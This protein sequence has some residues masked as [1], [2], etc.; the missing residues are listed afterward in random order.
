M[1]RIVRL[2]VLVVTNLITWLCT[3]FV[4]FIYYHIPQNMILCGENLKYV[5]ENSLGDKVEIFEQ[6][7]DGF[8][9]SVFITL[10]F[11]S[12]KNDERI[13]ILSYDWENVESSMTWVGDD[14]IMISIPFDA[15]FGRRLDNINNIKIEYKII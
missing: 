5:S 8:G 3:A 7:C 15:Y 13:E 1:R 10:A 14:K 6:V 2:T 11:I 9:G 12:H 4:L